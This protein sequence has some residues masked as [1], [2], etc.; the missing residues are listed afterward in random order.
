[1]KNKLTSLLLIILIIIPTIMGL[2]VISSFIFIGFN[3]Y[4]DFINISN[5]GEYGQVGDFFSGH[6]N[7]FIL[8]TIIVSLYFQ[9]VSIKQTWES[10]KQQSEANQ[11]ISEDLKRSIEANELQTREFI[12]TNYK[13]DFN[14][15]IKYIQSIEKDLNLEYLYDN[16]FKKSHKLNNQKLFELFR[17]KDY[18]AK[19][20][21]NIKDIELQSS[22]RHKFESAT[23]G[24][25]NNKNQELLENVF[26]FN[27]ILKIFHDFIDYIHKNKIEEN[28][29]SFEY[30]YEFLITKNQNK[31]YSENV[32]RFELFEEISS[33]YNIIENNIIDGKK[34]GFQVNMQELW[35]VIFNCISQYR[36]KNYFK[37]IMKDYQS[38]L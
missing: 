16:E 33:T 22:L 26:S 6:I 28:P 5:L 3:H 15:E 31:V 20:I 30:I 37:T 19:L 13:N 1:M 10:I 27:E 32:N 2:V 34:V 14:E 4:Q 35:E 12:T 24:R 7:G 25:Y 9:R 38:T 17:R 8:L 29:S 23:M 36:V 21:D 18:L 11:T